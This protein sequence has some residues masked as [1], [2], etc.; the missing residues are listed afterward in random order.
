MGG[1]GKLIDVVHQGDLGGRFTFEDTL[2]T[3]EGAYG[4]NDP[5]QNNSVGVL[6]MRACRP[7]RT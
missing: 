6:N 5:R 7:S 4:I 1:T 3:D 2:N